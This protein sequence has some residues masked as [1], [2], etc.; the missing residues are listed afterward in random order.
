MSTIL[1]PPVTP[2]PLATKSQEVIPHELAAPAGCYKVALQAGASYVIV[3]APR[4]PVVAI[5]ST[6]L[7]LAVFTNA[8]T[9][10]QLVDGGLVT[11]GLVCPPGMTVSARPDPLNIALINESGEDTV[12]YVQLLHS[13][14]I[15]GTAS[16][17]TKL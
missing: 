16:Q 3:N 4:T 10:P 9:A 11:G 8:A 5:A 15:L 17:M 7:V 14:N 1:P 12:V 6:G 13:W 2:Y